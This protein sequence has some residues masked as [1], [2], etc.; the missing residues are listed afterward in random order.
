MHISPVAVIVTS[1]SDITT[2]ITVDITVDTTVDILM[3]IIV[4]NPTDITLDITVDIA[5]GITM[6][7]NGDIN[8][9]LAGNV[10]QFPLCYKLS[11]TQNL[12]PF[13]L[14]STFLSFLRLFFLFGSSR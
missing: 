2:D 12:H 5:K 4:T 1:P 13:F 8:V 3:A 11:L 9:Y 7:I 10:Y 14:I 6:D